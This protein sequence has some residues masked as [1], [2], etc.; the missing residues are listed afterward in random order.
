MNGKNLRSGSDIKSI[1]KQF[2]QEYKINDLL[3]DYTLVSYKTYILKDFNDINSKTLIENKELNNYLDTN[4]KITQDY[5]IEI[6]KRKNSFYPIL[7]Q[8]QTNDNNT[9]LKAL[10]Y[11]ERI[12]QNSNLESIIQSTI[13]NICAY[14]GII[15]GLGW[16]NIKRDILDIAQKLRS[17]DS[18][19]KYYTIN[20]A[21]LKESSINSV[22]MI[23]IISKSKTISVLSH[24]SLLLSGGFLKVTK[25]EILL[26]YQKPTYSSTW[27]NIYGN[28]YGIG[29][30]YPI[31][32]LAGEGVEITQENDKILYTAI[33]DGFVSIV[34]NTMLI[35]DIIML[36]YINP[37]NLLNI[38]EQ[39]IES[40]VVK[41]DNLT[42][43]VISSGISLNIDT[44]KIVGNVGAANIISKDLFIKGQVHIKSHIKTTRA[45][46][47]HFKGKLEAKEAEIRYCENANIECDEL[48]INYINGSRIYFNNARISKIKSNNILFVQKSLNIGVMEG[49]NNEFILYPCSYGEHKKYLD[50]LNERLLNLNKLKSIFLADENR[51]NSDCINNTLIYESLESKNVDFTLYDWE[52]L[53]NKYMMKKNNS[54]QV[55]EKYNNLIAN[56]S[57]QEN[58]VRNEINKKLE[59][60]FDI[61]II[62]ENKC[63][64][65]FYIRFIN[66]YGVESRY[67]VSA[68]NLNP[69]KRVMLNNTSNA[70]KIVCYKE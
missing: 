49:Q 12:P 18:H 27:R 42:K 58:E 45:S 17:N 23:L 9:E 7:I 29:T 36:N 10:I 56:I 2:A 28:I 34:N 55:L 50:R 4:Y 30:S 22:A 40:L 44:L 1:L 54:T 21:K 26:S 70:I 38:Q 48:L 51:L 61:E 60:M 43:D 6:F 41:N 16:S 3:L 11:T 47:L 65:N 53:M 37:Q 59:E 52:N 20:I 67:N 32:I 46:I 33:K 39:G 57:E 64:I 31:G 35:S 63:T 19:P 62:F 25:G 15:I 14:R 24:N 13:L 8:L 5:T 69:I 68:S 66:F